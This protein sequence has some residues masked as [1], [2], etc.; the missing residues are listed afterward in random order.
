VLNESTA[1]QL[2]A[3]LGAGVANDPKADGFVIAKLS[4]EHIPTS[5]TE[6]TDYLKTRLPAEFYGV[7]VPIASGTVYFLWVRDGPAWRIL[8]ASLVCM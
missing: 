4:R 3:Q 1:V 8:H 7:F 6:V 5:S 2:G